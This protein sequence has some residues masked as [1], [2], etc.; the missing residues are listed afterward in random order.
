MIASINEREAWLAGRRNG[1][2]ASDAPAVLGISPFKSRGDLWAEKTGLVEPPDLSDNEAVE[3]GLRL[4]GPI[5]EA[6]EKR[7]GRIVTRLPSYASRRH[8]VLD[9]M[10][11]T[12]DALQTCPQKV[13]DVGILQI[14]TTSAFNASDWSEAPPLYYQVQLQHEL[15]VTGRNWGSLACLV[16]GQ[17]LVWF[18]Q[19]RNERFVTETLI[20]ALEE[21]W[22]CVKTKTRPAEANFSADVVKAMH[23]NDNGESVFLPPEAAKWAQT[24]EEAAEVRKDAERR[25]EAAKTLLKA[26]IGDASYGILPDGT[27][28]SYKTQTRK[29]HLVAASTFR[30]LR[31]CK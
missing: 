9:W 10:S 20:P 15:A 25:E 6:F 29:E 16:G 31:K 30:V 12:P 4:E 21:F 11:C 3:W 18:D 23:P 7:T 22:N 1:I 8:P 5:A 28:Y 2:G 17:K 26:A 19:D 24:A 27:T 13:G 14:K